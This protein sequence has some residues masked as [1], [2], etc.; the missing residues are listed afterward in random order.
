MIKNEHGGDGGNGGDGCGPGAGGKGGM[1]KPNG[2]PGKPGNKICLE[3]KK[4]A[5]Q[6]TTPPVTVTPT[7]PTTPKTGNTSTIKV[8]QYN[9]KYLPIDQLIIESEV[10]CGADHWHAAEGVVKATD[11]S[12][13]Q[14]P[15]PQ[16]GYG[17]VSGKPTMDIAAPQAGTI[18]VETTVGDVQIKYGQ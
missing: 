15:G 2:A 10:G 1:G 4:S 11:G 7:T 9:G 8:I 16:C 5:T 18:Q 14:D 17:K 3:E 6:V 13:V 12:F